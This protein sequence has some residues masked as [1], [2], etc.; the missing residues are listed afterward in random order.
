TRPTRADTHLPCIHC[1]K[2]TKICSP[3]CTRH[4]TY[5]QE[6]LHQV[7][8]LG[9]KSMPPYD[10]RRKS[11]S[12]WPPQFHQSVSSLPRCTANQKA[13]T[14]EQKEAVTC[15][16]MNIGRSS[17]LSVPLPHPCA[18]RTAVTSWSRRS[19]PNSSKAAKSATIGSATHV[20]SHQARPFRSH[21]IDRSTLE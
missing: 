9:D 19:L 5:W 10:V 21:L 18:A 20:A 17:P 13:W 15:S 7:V 12:I 14:G 16:F 2:S 3:Q 11:L 8:R 6:S 4:C 1:V